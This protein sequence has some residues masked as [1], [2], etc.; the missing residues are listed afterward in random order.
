MEKKFMDA[1][2]KRKSKY[3]QVVVTHE[4]KGMLEAITKETFRSGSGEVAFLVH[5]AYKK[6]QDRKPYD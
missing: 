4:V 5:Q 1:N 6:L 2:E 3:T